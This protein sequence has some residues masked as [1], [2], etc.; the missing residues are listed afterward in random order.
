[1]AKFPTHVW[2][3]AT[4]TLEFENEETQTR[5]YYCDKESQGSIT[6][7]IQKLW[8]ETRGV[9]VDGDRWDVELT[10]EAISLEEK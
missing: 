10:L 9:W 4:I 5:K 6:T 8:D 1:M 7:S 3:T 2:K